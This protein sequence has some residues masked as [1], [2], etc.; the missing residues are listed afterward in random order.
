MNEEEKA[1]DFDFD[2]WSRMAQEEPE[3]FESMRRQLI[4]DL[5]AQAPKHFKPRM[6]SLQWQV[7][8]VRKQA[9]NPMDTCLQI[10]QKM[11]NNVHGENGLLS[12][13]QEPKKLIHTLEKVSAGKILTFERPKSGK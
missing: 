2:Q 10:S 3:K 8:Q 6:I 1:S 12:A 4:D 11:W 5:I 7:D 9:S 13:L